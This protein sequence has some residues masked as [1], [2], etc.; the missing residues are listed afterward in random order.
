[1]SDE[2]PQRKPRPA[3]RTNRRKATDKASGPRD[4]PTPAPPTDERLNAMR[5]KALETE[6]LLKQNQREIDRAANEMV[7]M[8]ELQEAERERFLA[9]DAKI[10]ELRGQ[11]EELRRQVDQRQ[12]SELREQVRM[13]REQLQIRRQEVLGASAG[14]VTTHCQARWLGKEPLVWVVQIH[15]N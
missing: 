12:V 8:M 9:E 11:V 4:L 15:W 10:R 14:C 7:R 2:K 5:A 3:P 1:M 13:L 6:R